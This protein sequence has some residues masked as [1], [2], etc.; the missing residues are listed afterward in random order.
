MRSISAPALFTIVLGMLA[1]SSEDAPDDDADAGASNGGSAGSAGSGAG[2]GGSKAGSGGSAG[3]SAG[4]SSSG[5]SA[6]NSASGGKAG[7]SGTSGGSGAGGEAGK[8]GAGIGGG[9][10]G[11]AGMTGGTGG[12]GGADGGSGAEAGGGAGGVGGSGGSGG[13]TGMVMPMPGMN[14]FV[15]SKGMPAGGNLGSLEDADAFCKMLA[16]DVSEG[17][18]AKTW[19]AYLSTTTVDARDRIG[20]GPWRNQAGVVIANNIEDLHAQEPGEALD[21]TWPP[22]DLEIALTETGEQVMNSVHDILTGSNADGTLFE[23][24]NCNDWTSDSDMDTAGVGHSN[25]D[26]GGRPPSFNATH[27]VGCAPFT[28]NY[29]DGTVS[30]GGGRGSLYCFAL[31]PS[32]EA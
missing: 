24:N 10:A 20:A 25:R 3:T 12:S 8:G 11:N 4:T 5:G 22:A 16:T 27:T 32:P 2:S 28:S 31:E 17:L 15:T 9:M 1:C 13:S 7:A 30:S 26:G 14:F 23:D 29:E 21:D 19:R 6:G 18:G